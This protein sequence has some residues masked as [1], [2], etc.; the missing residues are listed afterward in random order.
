MRSVRPRRAPAVP[1]ESSFHET[2]VPA[3]VHRDGRDPGAWFTP[4]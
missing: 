2:H 4:T 1:G 3:D